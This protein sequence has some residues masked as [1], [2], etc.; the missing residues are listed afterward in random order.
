MKFIFNLL[1]PVFIS[2]GIFAQPGKKHNLV[3]DSLAKSWDQGIPLG[4]GW[5]GELIWQKENKLR[6]SLDR[7]DLWD[8][9]PMPM[10]D[11]LSFSWVIDKVN[12]S[13]YDSV[14]KLGDEPYERSP[15]PTKIPGAAMEFDLNKLGK[16]KSNEL[17]I[18]R[19]L[20]IIRFDNGIVFYNYV[21]AIKQAG[22]FIFDSLPSSGFSFDNLLPELIAPD[23]FKNSDNANANSLT[24]QELGNL[25]YRKGLISKTDNS[26]LYH[27]PTWGGAYYEVFIHWKKISATKLIG[28]WTIKNGQSAR[29][30]DINFSSGKNDPL[31]SHIQWWKDFWGRS[32][33]SI[34]DHLLEKQYYLEMYKFGSVARSNTPPISL[35]AVW[36]ADNGFLPPWKGDIHND[37]NTELSYWP[38]YASNHLDLTASFTNWLWKVRAENIRWT[39]SY[40]NVSGLNVPGVATISGKPMG[41]W[42]QYSMSPTTVFWLTQHFYWQWK[43]GM[44]KQ[45]LEKKLKPYFKSVS[46]Y[47][48]GIIDPKTHQ[49]ALSSSPE[50]NDNTIKAWFRQYT[51][52]D[53]AL[54]RYFLTKNNEVFY[55]DYANKKSILLNSLPDFAVNETGLTISPGFDLK[56]S[57]RHLSPYMAIYPLCL[58]DINNTKDTA[59]IKNSIRHIESLGTGEWCG[60]SFSWMASVYARAKQA[61]SAVKQLQIFASH[62]C[63]SNSFHLNGDQQG[64]PYSNFTYS[65]FTLEGNFA[66][67]EGVQELLLQN[68]GDLIE[69][70]PAVPEK[71][72]NVSFKSF[73]AEG[74]FLISAEK[75]NGFAKT[76]KIYSEHGGQLKIK[77]PFKDW[78]V[79]GKDKNNISSKND[80][81]TMQT[82]KGQTIVFSNGF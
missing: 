12:K 66:F 14:Q 59:V 65:P 82:W 40:F 33:V 31:V 29:L 41:G 44:D 23:Y 74:A 19:A 3:F 49:L 72:R 1:F 56:V 46:E 35:Q 13:Q 16:V 77:L 24:G 70:F 69:V 60:Y 21:H 42:V 4:N 61:D 64:G 32:S 53:L 9:R 39:K 43:Y 71:W 18:T 80:V 36:T 52:Y 78:T 27:Q 67:A 62:F 54:C 25:G 51:N 58:L 55:N 76:V 63:S 2:F 28:E 10:I 38:G 7:V 26:I 47:L 20:S 22:Y 8:D 57:H 34:P 45:F 48:S 30:P 5:L 79:T 68:H 37:L 81:L 17:D 11:K 73:R 15:A 6:I 50:I 75:V